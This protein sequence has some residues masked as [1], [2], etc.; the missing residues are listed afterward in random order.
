MTVNSIVL[1]CVN[2]YNIRNS[3]AMCGQNDQQFEYFDFS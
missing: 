3:H 2:I 1:S